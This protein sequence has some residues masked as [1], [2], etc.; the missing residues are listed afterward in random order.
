MEISPEAAA[1][2]AKL[3]ELLKPKKKLLGRIFG[4]KSDSQEMLQGLEMGDYRFGELL[5]VGSVGA[6]FKAQNLSGDQT[7]AIK[8]I[9]L[10]QDTAPEHHALF[11]RELAIGKKLSHPAVLKTYDDMQN[12]LARFLVLE[13]AGG[14]TLEQ[15][16]E[17]PWPLDKVVDIFGPVVEGLQHAHDQG[18]VHRDLKPENIMLGSDGQVKILDFGLARMKGSTELTLTGQFKG[19]ISYAAPE[20]IEDTKNVTAACDQF[21]LGMI[22][23]EALSGSLPYEVDQADPMAAIFARLTEPAASLSSKRPETPESLEQ[24]IA[25]ML[26]RNPEDRF[27]SVTEAFNAIR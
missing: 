20:Q 2:I 4:A 10:G 8:A 11:E 14:Q 9:N 27:A 18:V 3:R 22:L 17:S 12:E 26:A 6:V 5:G 23:F 1:W 16:F 15:L 19:T 13:Y 7:V 21:A 25:K 24:A